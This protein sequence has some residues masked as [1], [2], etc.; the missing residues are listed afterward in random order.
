MYSDFTLSIVFPP[1]PKFLSGNSLIVIEKNSCGTCI[2]S[3]DTSVKRLIKFSFCSSDKT[4]LSIVIYGILILLSNNGTPIIVVPL[5][6]AFLTITSTSYTQITMNTTHSAT[7]TPPIIQMTHGAVPT[8]TADRSITAGTTYF[9]GWCHRSLSI[10]QW[11]RGRNHSRRTEPM[12]LCS[13]KMTAHK[14]V[15]LLISPP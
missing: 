14:M 15:S 6:S 5:Y 10:F 7:K 3:D 11:R 8:S 2:I 12:A 1:I 9:L 13:A 4:P